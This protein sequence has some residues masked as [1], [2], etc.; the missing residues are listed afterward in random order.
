MEYAGAT[1]GAAFDAIAERVRANTEHVLR[2]A[3]ERGV[4][5]RAAAEALAAGRVR[6]AM[7]HRRFAI[8]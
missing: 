7:A 8:M 2:A 1:R 6:Q 4:A 3:R 5:P